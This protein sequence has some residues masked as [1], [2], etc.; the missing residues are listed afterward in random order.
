V[1]L[2][3]VSEEVFLLICGFNVAG[4]LFFSL[5]NVYDA[6]KSFGFKALSF[7]FW[8]LVCFAIAFLISGFKGN[9][10]QAGVRKLKT[11]WKDS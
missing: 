6:I 3:A 2:P 7:R 4:L 10:F 5:S 11:R 1:V 8:G 9:L